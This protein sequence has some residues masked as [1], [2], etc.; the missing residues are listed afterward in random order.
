MKKVLILFLVAVFIAAFSGDGVL[1]KR[2]FEKERPERHGFIG[3]PEVMK[4]KLGLSDEQIDKISEIN[5]D[6]KKR[7]LEYREKIAPK[8]TRLRRMLLEEDVDLQGVRSLLKE[9][10][11]LRLEV[12]MLRIKQRLDIE[13]ILTPSQRT[14]VKASQ[15]EM[16]RRP[17]GKLK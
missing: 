1:A 5:L 3:N 9:I 4:E 10:S 2:P 17:Q 8:K 15:R 14:R 12:I 16:R 7:Y 6:Y 11:N 13:K